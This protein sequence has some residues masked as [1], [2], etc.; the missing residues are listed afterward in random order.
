MNRRAKPIVSA[1]GSSSVPAATTRAAVTCSSRPAR[2]GAFAD[3]RE[4]IVTQRAARRPE[5][6]VGDLEDPRPR[7]P[8]RRGD[9][10]SPARGDRRRAASFRADNQVGTWMPLVMARTGRWSSGTP[11]QIGPH[12]SRVTSPCSWLTALIAARRAQRQ[13]GHVELQPAA[14]VVVRRAPGSA[15]D[16]SPSVPQ[17]PA[18]CVSTRWNGKA[19]CPAATGVW[20]VKIVVRR[21]SSSAASND[22]PCSIRSRMR[23]RTTNAAWPSLRCQTA[24]ADPSAFSARTPP[25]AEDDFLLHARLAIA[26]V[27]ARRQLAI[28]RRVLFEIGVEQV[29]LDAAEPDAP[30]RHE[31]AAIAERDRRRCRACRRA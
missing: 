26:A 10:A 11:G 3:E 19:S 14:V 21:T 25:I 16:R 30:H 28:P 15:P 13:R 31:H 12:M 5:L 29:Q 23:C 6:L 7:P 8:D 9:R 1:L 18:R 24:G 4:E 22:C 20:V 17:H 2:A 27:E